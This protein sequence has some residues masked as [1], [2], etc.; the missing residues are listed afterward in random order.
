MS[1]P[2]M[3]LVS[4]CIC[5]SL[6]S[7]AKQRTVTASGND[8]QTKVFQPCGID[9][10]TPMPMACG[11]SGVQLCMRVRG[12]RQ[13]RACLHWFSKAAYAWATSGAAGQYSRPTT[14]STRRWAIRAARGLASVP[15]SCSRQS[16]PELG[17]GNGTRSQQRPALLSNQAVQ[18]SA[19]AALHPS[20]AL[21]H[22]RHIVEVHGALLPGE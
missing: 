7:N 22:L 13:A 18:M 5:A 19:C 1:R 6:G 14:P 20:G 8:L 2:G 21:P 11:P 12:V 10:H 3:P 4:C 17:R 16:A 15:A 9:I